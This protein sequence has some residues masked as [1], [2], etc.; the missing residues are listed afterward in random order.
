MKPSCIAHWELP[1]DERENKNHYLPAFGIVMAVP[2]L[3][4]K[5]LAKA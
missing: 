5:A 4:K 3:G 2:A 1:L